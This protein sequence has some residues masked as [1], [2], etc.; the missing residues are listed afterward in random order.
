MTWRITLSRLPDMRLSDNHKRTQRWSYNAALAA[1]EREAWGWELRAASEGCC[2][3]ADRPAAPLSLTWEVRWP[4]HI[5]RDPDNVLASLKPATDSCV[6]V[7]LIP[8]DDHRTIRELTIRSLMGRDDAG[9]TLIIS[10]AVAGLPIA[11]IGRG[12]AI[13]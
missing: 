11:S 9:T 13:T 10:S 5:L 2:K 1:V 7:G 3:E 8:S 12:G 4:D 6:D